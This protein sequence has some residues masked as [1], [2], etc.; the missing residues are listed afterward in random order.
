MTFN[1]N[2]I[3]FS[4]F[5]HSLDKFKTTT[6]S[7]EKDHVDTLLNK[8]LVTLETKISSIP[9]EVEVENILVDIPILDVAEEKKIFIVINLIEKKC[10]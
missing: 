2:K 9:L 4:F 8:G 6:V 7:V 3:D 10:I 5:K 1:M